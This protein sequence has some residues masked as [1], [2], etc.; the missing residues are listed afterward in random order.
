MKALTSL[1]GR[2]PWR[3]KRVISVKRW[4]KFDLVRRREQEEALASRK[5]AQSNKASD[6]LMNNRT[7]IQSDRHSD[8][9]QFRQTYRRTEG[10]PCIQTNLQWDKHPQGQ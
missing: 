4:L 9:P 6:K 2:Q 5:D 7:Y 1:L 3:L 10:Q 8:G